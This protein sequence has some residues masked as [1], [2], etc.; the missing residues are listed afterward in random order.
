M[1][2]LA[3]IRQA[4]FGWVTQGTV[5]IAAVLVDFALGAGVGYR[6]GLRRNPAPRA[7]Q[8]GSAQTRPGQSIGPK[9][10]PERVVISAVRPGP[11]EP[12]PAAIPKDLGTLAQT[13]TIALPDLPSTP[14]IH[15]SLFALVKGS[16]VTFRNV[17]WA[18]SPP[19]TPVNV[20]ATTTENPFTVAI[21]PCPVVPKWAAFALISPNPLGGLRYGAEVER[22]FGPVV[23]GA[24]SIGGVTFGKVGWRW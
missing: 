13:T 2:T 23:V 3:E 6:M 4:Y 7:I 18:E 17:V 16:N 11:P 9:D 1:M 10:H 8:V 14:I 12:P 5:L 15:D 20:Q 22:A 21:P 19:G 24:G